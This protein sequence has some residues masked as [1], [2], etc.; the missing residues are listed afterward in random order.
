M[1]VKSQQ[2]AEEH[3][4]DRIVESSH[5]KAPNIKV[6]FSFRGFAFGFGYDDDL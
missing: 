2:V 4:I 6:L 1:F 5:V 3:I